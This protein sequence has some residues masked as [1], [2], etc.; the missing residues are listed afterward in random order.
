M[1]WLWLCLYLFHFG[2]KVLFIKSCQPPVASIGNHLTLVYILYFSLMKWA[3]ILKCLLTLRTRQR[4]P[5]DS[6][7]HEILQAGILEWGCHVLLQGIFPTQESN[8][9]FPHCGQTLYPLSHQGSPNIGGRKFATEIQVLK[10]IS[11]QPF[12]DRLTKK[13]LR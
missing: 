7:V 5:P 13:Q 12:Y 11:N 8:P 3:F 10:I 4:R 1:S 6:S 9:G 2:L